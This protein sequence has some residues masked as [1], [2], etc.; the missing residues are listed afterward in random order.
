M[1]PLPPGSGGGAH[2][3]AREGLGESQFRRGD[4]HGGT[5][6]MYLVEQVV[7][8]NLGK[9][10]FL[11]SRENRGGTIF[12]YVPCGASSFRESGKA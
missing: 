8:E 5:L 3:L 9:P 10:E 6:F 1:P 4:I 2:L 11:S 12:I 7:L